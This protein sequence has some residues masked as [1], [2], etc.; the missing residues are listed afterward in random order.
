MGAG[1]SIL[2]YMAF[3]RSHWIRLYSTNPLERVNKEVRRRTNVVGIFPDDA[4]V[5]RLVGSV[6]IE[7][8]DDWQEGRRYF[9]KESM[10]AIYEP[11]AELIDAP[12][13]FTLTPIK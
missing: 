11:E 6:L 3:P 7:L 13:P 2:S 10:A 5:E 9:S 8:D 4:S 12:T 1:T